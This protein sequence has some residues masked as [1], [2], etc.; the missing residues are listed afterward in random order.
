MFFSKGVNQ[1]AKITH[2]KAKD[3]LINGIIGR[4]IVFEECMR[5]KGCKGMVLAIEIGNH[6][7]PVVGQNSEPLIL[8]VNKFM[9]HM[10]I[11]E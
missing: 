9:K 11:E 6:L 2:V 4:G 10:R 3:I 8:K 1:E 5:R 7:S